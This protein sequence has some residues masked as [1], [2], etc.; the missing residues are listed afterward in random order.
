[1]ENKNTHLPTN[2]DYDP[3]EKVILFLKKNHDRAMDLLLAY[4]EDL[5]VIEMVHSTRGKSRGRCDAWITA[6]ADL[7]KQRCA[8]CIHKDACAMQCI[9]CLVA[10][11]P[12]FCAICRVSEKEA[13]LR[14][15]T[16]RLGW[17]KNP[18]RT[19]AEPFD[20][21]RVY[22][23]Q[24]G[25]A[26]REAFIPRAILTL[27]LPLYTPAAGMG[28]AW[29][30]KMQE[31]L[32]RWFKQLDLA[33][34]DDVALLDLACS[35]AAF[36][37]LFLRDLYDNTLY[38]GLGSGLKNTGTNESANVLISGLSGQQGV[39]DDEIMKTIDDNENQNEL[40][41]GRDAS[42]YT[43][44]WV[45]DPAEA[46]S[47]IDALLGIYACPV[48]P[49]F[50]LKHIDP[51]IRKK[52]DNLCR[53][54]YLRK[55]NVKVTPTRAENPP[56]IDHRYLHYRI[57]LLLAALLEAAQATRFTNKI[58]G[59]FQ[60]DNLVKLWG[61][62]NYGYTLKDACTKITTKTGKPITPSAVI[63]DLNRHKKHHPRYQEYLEWLVHNNKT[64]DTW[65]LLVEPPLEVIKTWQEKVNKLNIERD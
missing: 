40:L 49:E 30:I 32:H 36:T 18:D 10:A 12:Q 21:F 51:R 57:Y 61:Y 63:Q 33:R 17:L 65:Q 24:L 47:L 59:V 43:R 44:S 37:Y 16:S 56:K 55:T 7:V 22:D 8:D 19:F 53:K 60:G 41:L 3:P 34:N 62:L 1:M 9:D 13:C 58:A 2:L 14:N 15:K 64:H 5:P 27:P 23:C 20:G 4:L 52:L 6:A 11:L 35:V 42:S 29:P 38:L 39:S 45:I 48:L 46:E 50:E 26:K 28:A 54:G 31:Q 25:F